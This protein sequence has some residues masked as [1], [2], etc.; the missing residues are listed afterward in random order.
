[1]NQNVAFAKNSCHNM[2]D[3]NFLDSK[4]LIIN[5]LVQDFESYMVQTRVKN[6]DCFT[7]LFVVSEGCFAAAGPN[8]VR[9]II[10]YLSRLSEVFS[11]CQYNLFSLVCNPPIAIFVISAHLYT[12][13]PLTTVFLSLLI[14]I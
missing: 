2:S 9:Q 7:E 11:F 6:A 3:I 5:F 4:S 13:S 14:S 10:R 12:Y 1:M 8:N